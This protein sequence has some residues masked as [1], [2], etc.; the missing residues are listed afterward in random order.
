MIERMDTIEAGVDFYE[1]LTS[2][3][4]EIESRYRALTPRSQQA[5]ARASRVFPGGYTRD[6]IIRGPHPTFIDSASGAAMRDLDGRTLTDFWFNATSLILGHAHP[7]VVAA[8]AAQLPRGTAYFAPTQNEIALAEL[9]LGRLPGSE[10]IRF[11]N[12]GSEA[13][14]MAVRFARAFRGKSTIV[15]FEG[16][17]HGSYDDVSWS[18]APKVADAGGDDTPVAV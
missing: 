15:K 7:A 12:S 17:Y 14:M 16:S 5:F 2:R 4:S 6:A 3:A 13:V 18:V 8:M 10:R 1:A 9:V 11:A